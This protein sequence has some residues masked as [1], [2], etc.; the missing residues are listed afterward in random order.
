LVQVTVVPDFTFNSCGPKVKLPILIATS[1]ARSGVAAK[2]SNATTP[3]MTLL[4]SDFV[5]LVMF[6]LILAAAY[7]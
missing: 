6:E 3:A 4:V 7:R 2:R 1:S 5:F